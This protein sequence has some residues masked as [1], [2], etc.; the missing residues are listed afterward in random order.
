AMRS[1]ADGAV[2]VVLASYLGAL[3]FSPIQVGA[4]VAGT[5]LGS[6]A[7]TL[8]VGLRGRWIG[9]RRVLLGA[10][11]LMVATGLGFATVPTFWPALVIAVAGT[12]NPSA[13]DVSV[14]LPTEQAVLSG[15]VG[16][17]E[18]TQL[19]AWYNLSGAFAAAVGA[20][21]SAIPVVAARRYGITVV[22]A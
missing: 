13:G 18:R 16:D 19:F 21:A 22:G 3:G 7:L 1:F 6:A 20:L 14:F 8:V 9:Q 11:G 5:L 2:S 17:A 15:A 12:L 10:C 4:I